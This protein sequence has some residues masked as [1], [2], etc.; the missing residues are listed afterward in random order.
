M[1]FFTFITHLHIGFSLIVLRVRSTLRFVWINLRLSMLQNKTQDLPAAT[2]RCGI[3]PMLQNKTPD[4]LATTFRCGISPML[5]NK[6][7]D[8]PA[9]TFQCG[10]SPM[11]QNK[12]QDLPDTTFR[13][14]I[15]PMLQNKSHWCIP[16]EE[17]YLKVSYRTIKEKTYQTL[18]S[19]RWNMIN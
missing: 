10:I 7:Q 9:T 17:H 16:F 3:S 19:P 11:L 14:G 6:T 4:L 15:S 12:T 5:Q 13:C 1:V 18:A 8:L 2:F